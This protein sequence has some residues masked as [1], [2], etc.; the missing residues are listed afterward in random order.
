M[1]IMLPLMLPV[2]TALHADLVWFGIVTVLAVEI[3]LLTP[4][5]GISVFVIKATLG[6]DSPITLE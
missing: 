2:M 3:G 1:L 5:F 6:T 4:P